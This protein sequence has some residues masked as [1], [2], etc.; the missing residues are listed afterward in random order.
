M[1]P[2]LSRVGDDRKLDEMR[3]KKKHSRLKY[4]S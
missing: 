1:Y 2:K 3:L 4:V